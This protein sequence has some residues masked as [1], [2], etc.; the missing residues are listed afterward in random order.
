MKRLLYLC[1]MVVL[2][3]SFSVI[4]GKSYAAHQMGRAQAALMPVRLCSS[5][6]VGIPADQHLAQGIFNGADL[7]TK[8]W[9]ARFRA[10]GMNL[11]PVIHYDYARADAS[12]TD[13]AKE[14]SNALACVGRT[15]TFGYD[16]TLNSSIAL[17]SEPITNQAGMVMISP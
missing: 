16:G 15:D 13:P 4:G 5:T 2:V 17:I 9:K 7:A 10:A 11:L 1:S 8:Q 3:T 6:P 12:G 14:R